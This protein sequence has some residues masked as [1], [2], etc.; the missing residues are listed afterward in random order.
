MTQPQDAVFRAPGVGRPARSSPLSWVEEDS[1]RAKPEDYILKNGE[2][3]TAFGEN[4][5][6]RERCFVSATN[7]RKNTRKRDADTAFGGDIPE[8]ESRVL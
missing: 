5:G 1:K 3:G 7:S 8:M 6:G 4:K 2:W